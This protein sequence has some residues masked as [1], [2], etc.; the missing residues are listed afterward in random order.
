VQEVLTSIR[1]VQAFAREDYE[2]E[3]FESRSLESVEMALQARAIKAKLSPFVEVIV[4]AGTCLVLGYGARLVL[5][6]QLSAGVLVVFLLYLKQ[7][8]KP[9]RELSKMTDTISKAMVSYERIEEILEIESRVKD[10]PGAKPAPPFKGKIEFDHVSFTYDGQRPV[11]KDVSFVIEPGQVAAIVGPSGTGKTTIVSLI[12]R[13]FDPT[14][15]QAKIDGTDVRRYKLKSLRDQISFVLQ[16]TFLFHASVLENIAYGRPTAKRSEI[17]EAAKMANAHEFIEKMP[18]GYETVIGERGVTLSGG[19]RQRI[20]IARAII[21]N[22][23]ILILDEPTSGLD[24]ASEQAVMQALNRLMEGRTC[25]IIAHHLGTISNADV[26]FVIRDSELVEK[27]THEELLRLGGVYAGLEHIQ[28][29]V[30]AER[31]MAHA[32][33]Q[34]VPA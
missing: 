29:S 10:L 24:A 15:G 25:V 14:S 26:I 19:E 13:F 22:A 28:H 30:G 27:G 18:E 32:D 5:G 23:P 3:R 17:I 2:E 31:K 4:A 16:E 20:A 33:D 8:Y 9:M 34:K 7:M 21:R 11:L 6:G 12:P 1:L